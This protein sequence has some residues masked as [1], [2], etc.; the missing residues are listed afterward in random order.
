MSNVYLVS[1]NGKLSS[2]NGSFTYSDIDGSSRTLFP[3]MIDRITSIGSLNVT[4]NALSL[5]MENKI[6]IHFLSRSGKERG[7]LSFEEG[8]DVFLHQRQFALVS[9]LDE[10]ISIAKG[11]VYGKMKNQYRF[12][13]RHQA[14]K[15]TL[16]ELKRLIKLANETDDLNKLR[17]YEGSFAHIY[18]QELGAILPSW[19]EFKGRNS[20]PPKDPFNSVLSFLYTLSFSRVEHFIEKAGLNASVGVLHELSYGRKS[21]VC[22]LMEEF[23]VALGDAIACGLFNRKELSNEDFKSDESSVLI[24]KEAI[25]KIV[26]KFEEK[27][28][29]EVFYPR[30]ER[31]LP[32]WKIIEEQVV[33]YKKVLKGDAERYTPMYFR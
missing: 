29:S 30:L 10:R 9:S 25:K 33:L 20:H 32:Y 4:A 14:S 21:L 8:K 11:I 22:D 24:E 13:Q 18:F 15:E 17:G 12:I 5:L 31:N 16:F 23:R 2:S 27:L 6:N 26:K 1:Y 28:T 19:C 3:H 7:A